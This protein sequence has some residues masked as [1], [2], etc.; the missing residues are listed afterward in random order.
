MKL[1]ILLSSRAGKAFMIAC[2]SILLL[3]SCS[4]KR[5]PQPEP[6]GEAKVRYVN[7]SFGS[8]S[9][10]FYVNGTKKN[11]TPLNYGNTSEHFTITSGANTFNVND[12][13]TTTVNA[14]TQV[15]I[16][17]GSKYSI[18][19]YKNIDGKLAL[20][21]L[22]DAVS[23]PPAGKAN[24]RFINFNST[25]NSNMTISNDA[26]VTTLIPSLAY[27]GVS[28]FFPVDA[29]AKFTFSATGWISAAAYDGGIVAG[30][31]YT[32]WIDGNTNVN[33]KQLIGHIFEQN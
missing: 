21:F 30:K 4:K 6:V 11:V 26:G 25:L 29:G 5:D 3:A 27:F 9:Q 15:Q 2:A 20:A 23:T 8:L 32:I 33:N 18:F 16:A 31:S 12:A 7:A 28:D 13:G 22:A 24:V 1:P 17:I 14:S 19:Y 10:D